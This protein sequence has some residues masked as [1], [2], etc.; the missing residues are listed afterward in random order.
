M[1]SNKNNQMRNRMI[2]QYPKTDR[3]KLA[4]LERFIHKEY[5]EW[6]V[7]LEPYFLFSKGED[8]FIHAWPNYVTEEQIAGNYNINHPDLYL[9]N[10][11][12]VLVMEL[13]G[14]IHDIKTE[15][16]DK[17]NKRYELNNIPYIVINE[18]ELKL[19]L[20]IPKSN[21]LTQDQINNEF[22]ERFDNMTKGENSQ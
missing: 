13:D 22:K 17:R 18:S 20:A 10:D 15:K 11:Q 9:I 14:P 7:F 2:S 8:E 5:P 1:T 21:K 4:G 16:T 12:K 19:K 3:E 6:E